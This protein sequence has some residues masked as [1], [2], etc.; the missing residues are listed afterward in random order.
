MSKIPMPSRDLK[1]ALMATAEVCGVQWSE[2]AAALAVAELSRFPEPA[3]ISALSRCRREVA[4][5]LSLAHIIERI[6]DG[7]PG[8]DEAW[9]QISALGEEG[10]AVLTQETLAAW[11]E[12]RDLIES[13]ETGARMAFRGVYLRLVTASRTEGRP[14][15]WVPSLGKDPAGREAALREGAAVGRLDSRHAAELAGHASNDPKVIRAELEAKKP[16]GFLPAGPGA[17]RAGERARAMFGRITE[18]MKDPEALKRLEADLEEQ[19][20]RE[21]EQRVVSRRASGDRT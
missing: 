4:G 6:D 20:A 7:R 18:A 8:P 13:D 12:V 10:S 16:A 5:R 14:V 19:E 9:A 21:L 1:N 3:V 17:T 2:A 11:K 15:Q